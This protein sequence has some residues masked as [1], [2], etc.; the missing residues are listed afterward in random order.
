M[1]YIKRGT[2]GGVLLA[3]LAGQPA[4]AVTGDFDTN[5]YVDGAD[6]AS[7]AQCLALS[8]PQILSLSN[9]CLVAFDGDGDG[10]IDLCDYGVL[11]GRPGHTPFPLRDYAGNAITAESTAPYSGRHTCGA[12]HDIDE[13]SNGFLFQHGR[14]DLARNIV[15]KDDY[16]NDGRF[17][18]KGPGRYGV[19][20]QSFVY[21]LAAKNNTS[22]SQI[23]QTTFAWIRD[24]AGCHVGGGAGE[25]DR[26]G[27]M[28]YDVATGQF[29]YEK[30]GLGPGD[31]VLDGDYTDMNYTTGALGPARWDI[32]G[33]SGPDCL[34]CHRAQRAITRSTRSAPADPADGIDARSGFSGGSRADM[35]YTWRRGVFAAGTALVDALGQSVPAF[36]AAG[37]A[38]QGWFSSID[39]TA[40]PPVLQID[41]AAGVADG[42]LQLTGDVVNVAPSALV[43]IPRDQV[44]T[45][46]HPLATITGTVWF[47]ERD[48][49]YK[50]FNLMNDTDPG[51]DIPAERS[52]VCNYCHPGNAAHEFAKGNSP[53]VQQ[54]NEIDWQNFR[55]CRDCHLTE[56]A[57]GVPNP[58]HHPDAP[59]LTHEIHF[60]EMVVGD[61][62]NKLSC[63]ACH[64]PY[65]LTSALVFRD[66]TIPGATGTTAQYYSA[67][68][69]NPAS[70][71]KSRW[72]PSL[73]WKT[74]SDGVERL[75]PTN[76]WINIYWGDWNTNGTPGVLG[77]DVIAPIL[78]WRIT[79]AVGAT[80]LPVVTD[81]N[82]DGQLE[83]NR[84]EEI[85]AYLALLKGNDSYGRQIAARP[86]LVRGV[87]VWYADET[88]PTG[89][90]SF[91]HRG[92]GIPMTYHPYVWELDHN[93][94]PA[95]DAWGTEFGGWACGHCHRSWNGG[96]PTVVF[97]R[98]VLVDPYD[99]NGQP[100]YETVRAQTG[101]NPP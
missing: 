30:L 99:E 5:G 77:D 39:L 75:F 93:V 12:C 86:V 68:P 33:V 38:G 43:H 32:T 101:A 61:M 40:N 78:S 8:G 74:D 71:D 24:C 20:G 70:P 58:L 69:L 4:L 9:N 1:R 25:F 45:S 18:I 63:Q 11:Q 89:V 44:C 64:I 57:P 84:L 7:F 22:A 27:E 72:Y 92:T 51:N 49:H 97:D 73:T 16:F 98:K 90:S 56:L 53:Q 79:Q 67:D 29:G 54:R 87:R 13:I 37:T 14:T 62:I 46:C 28:L 3:V 81:D 85:L 17:W 6:F 47:D 59:E 26:D 34:Y 41:Y 31:V 19:W 36:A 83:I 2:V 60:P 65:P 23:E 76:L 35:N 80:P 88:S 91:D 66:I 21:K 52:Q 100:V 82:G 10:D 50:Q 95:A 48:V 55:S 96:Q 15:T 42:S 94:L